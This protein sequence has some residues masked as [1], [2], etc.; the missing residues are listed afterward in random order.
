[1]RA[2]G[3]W[4]MN[5]MLFPILASCALAQRA[6]AQPLEAGED[7]LLAST[8]EYMAQ[9]PQ[10]L[11]ADGKLSHELQSVALRGSW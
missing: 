1:M 9:H 7:K 4:L 6:I 2:G 10:L 11:C 3:G 5:A 8:A